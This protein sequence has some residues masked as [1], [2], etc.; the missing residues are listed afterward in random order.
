MTLRPDKRNTFSSRTERLL[1]YLRGSY[2]LCVAGFSGAI[3]KTIAF[4]VPSCANFH[5]RGFVQKGLSSGSCLLKVSLQVSPA[6][7][8]KSSSCA[9]LLTRIPFPSS[10]FHLPLLDGLGSGLLLMF[11]PGVLLLTL[12]VSDLGVT[13]IF[14]E[15]IGRT[16]WKEP[17]KTCSRKFSKSRTLSITCVRESV[18]FRHDR[19][20]R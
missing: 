19:N 9:E 2:P 20:Q 16:M 10:L 7:T 4:D 15:L 13:S 3:I 14:L 6:L 18:A 5:L 12:L 11:P 8:L 1:S 17:L